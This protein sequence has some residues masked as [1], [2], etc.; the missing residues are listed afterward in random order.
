M[1]NRLAKNVRHEIV[2]DA[3][4]RNDSNAF[5]IMVEVVHVKGTMCAM[6]MRWVRAGI[7]FLCIK[8]R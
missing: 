1:G 4:T 6:C 2:G 7:K 5:D 3:R 8:K